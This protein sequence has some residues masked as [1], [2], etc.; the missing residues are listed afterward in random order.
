[1]HHINTANNIVELAIPVFFLTLI[2]L[3]FGGVDIIGW[4]CTRVQQAHHKV[5]KFLQNNFFL[6]LDDEWWESEHNILLPQHLQY[7]N[8]ETNCSHTVQKGKIME[9]ESIFIKHICPGCDH[10]VTSNVSIS[11][12][13]ADAASVVSFARDCASC[14]EH[15]EIA[16]MKCSLKD[17]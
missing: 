13:I 16:F 15:L 1:M 8:K 6:F 2:F 10:K 12:E 14:K 17:T 7:K 11:A 5:R 3:L 4:I 9:T